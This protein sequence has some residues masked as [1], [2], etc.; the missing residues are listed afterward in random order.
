MRYFQLTDDLSR[1][2]VVSLVADSDTSQAAI[3]A[4]QR[5][6]AQHGCHNDY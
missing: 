1:L 4:V 3:K 5:G 2:A 6:V